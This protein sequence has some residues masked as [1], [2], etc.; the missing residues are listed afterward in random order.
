MQ[1]LSTRVSRGPLIAAGCMLGAAMLLVAC[2][3]GGAAPA[4]P[5]L[6]KTTTGTISGFGSVIVNGVRFDDR[7]AT[8]V[9]D[10]E[11]ASSN[12]ELKLGMEVE[13]QSDKDSGQASRIAYG[14]ALLGPVTSVNKGSTT[15]VVLGQTVRVTRS[16]VFGT[17][18]V[19]GINAVKVGSV[20]NVHG[21]F[22]ASTGT[23]V[24]SRVDLKPNAPVYRLRGLVSNLDT[25]AMTL[26]LGGQ[27]VSYKVLSA[28]EAPQGLANGKVFRARLE[29]TQVNGYWVARRLKS[30][31]SHEENQ[32]EA[33]K[34]GF[35][36][37][38]T[39]PTS[40]KV[41]GLTVD[42]SQ[43][44]FPGKEDSLKLGARVEIQGTVVNGVLMATKVEVNDDQ[45][46]HERGFELHGAIS[47]LD[48]SAKT[49]VLRTVTVSY[50]GT[51]TYQGGTAADLTGPKAAKVEVRG[52][53]SADGTILNATRIQFETN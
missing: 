1:I 26:N 47:A 21:L 8:V 53:M 37:E 4:A 52:V 24:A 10:D 18:L 22:D 38:F 31:E 6:G 14:S 19:G 5:V 33:H 30:A 23:T 11:A 15:L 35:I 12:N 34:S 39:S 46:E 40:F 7:T 29:T 13:I 3:G 17:D 20:V 25:A 41:N 42:A 9:G 32:H 44:R 45:K 51:V 36:T 27:P 16:T 43:V 2:G 49:F 50:A 28:T 48:A